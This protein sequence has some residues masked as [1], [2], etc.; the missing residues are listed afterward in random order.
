MTFEN[1]AVVAL[2][3]AITALAVA[4]LAGA[5]QSRPLPVPRRRF[6]SWGAAS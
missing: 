6:W 3:A 5:P 1:Y 4:V 2:S